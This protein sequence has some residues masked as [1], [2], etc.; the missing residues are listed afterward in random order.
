MSDEKPI[1]TDEKPIHSGAKPTH[2]GAKPT[3][4]NRPLSF[5]HRRST[6]H[7]YHSR[8]IYLITVCTAE[9]QP[10][11]GSLE[12]NSPEEAYIQPTA[13]GEEVLRC[14]N[15]IPTFQREA[16]EKKSSKTG[17]LCHREISL[18]AQQLMPDHFHGIIFVHSE[19]DIAIGE[20]IRGFMIGCTKAYNAAKESSAE[21]GSAYMPSVKQGGESSAVEGRAVAG[22]AY[23]PSVK[24]PPS[25]QQ[26]P[27][28]E[29][30]NKPLWEK[31]FHDRRLT[32][33]GQLQTMIDYVR[34]NPRRL[35][36]KRHY[37]G[38]F[39]VVHGVAYQ[40]H[41]FSAVGNLRWLDFPLYA[42]HVRRRFSEQERREYMNG[43]ILAARNGAVLIGAFIS[44]YEKQVREI[45]LREGW[46]I[47]QLCREEFTKFYKPSGD[48]FDACAKGQ[49]L[50]LHEEKKVETEGSAVQ[51]SAYMPSIKQPR[52][53]KQPVNAFWESQRKI[54]RNECVALNEL[55][56][57]LSEY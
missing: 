1:H 48:L 4:D 2:A 7:D 50:L 6:F 10:L 25:T 3:H 20:V 41:T 22:S 54:H 47:I 11:L 35:F 21:E 15:N 16:A 38:Q 37:S 28:V 5:S 53:H 14:W 34:D 46:A 27:S 42:V 45:A 40:G 30:R 43:C 56:E 12:G 44:E 33:E 49:V 31:G 32:R 8:G 9:R 24:Q 39:A 36:V 57:K 26:P 13:L 52:S 55:A 51:G 29:P 23:M 17:T 18:I 19:M